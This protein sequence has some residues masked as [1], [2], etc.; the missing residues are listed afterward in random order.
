VLQ[1]FVHVAIEPKTYS[2]LVH[3]LLGLPLGTIWFGVL[4]TG[5]TLAA[6]L[7]VFALVGIPLMLVM[8]YV[9]RAMGN[10][11]RMTANALLGTHLEP[12]GFGPHGHGNPWSRLRAMA[13][14]RQRIREFAY[15]LLRFPAGVATFTIAIAALTVPITLALAPLAARID[16]HEPFGSWSSGDDVEQ[17]FRSPGAWAAVPIAG[18]LFVAALHLTNA[19]ADICTRW[20]LHF[21]GQR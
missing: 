1:R 4:L 14:D 20:T 11:E 19:V 13:E 5:L 21:L 16:H 18:L 8:C 10:V 7:V 17:L 12:A 3:L 9:S 15:L 2:K 6:S